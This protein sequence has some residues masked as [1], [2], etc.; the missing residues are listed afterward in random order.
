MRIRNL[1]WRKLVAQS[2]ESRRLLSWFSGGT[3]WTDQLLDGRITRVVSELLI[4]LCE[5]GSNYIVHEGFP[6]NVAVVRVKW[7]FSSEGRAW[8]DGVDSFMWVV[9]PKGGMGGSSFTQEEMSADWGNF[10]RRG[11][12]LR[13]EASWRVKTIYELSMASSSACSLVAALSPL[14]NSPSTI[15][16][17]SSYRSP[18]K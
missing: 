13:M 18:W 7:T 6:V 15:W 10:K 4:Y 12:P 9:R 2:L 16:F 11:L 1:W 17:P 14:I 3:S 8:L 5:E